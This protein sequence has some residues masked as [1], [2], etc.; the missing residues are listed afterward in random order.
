MHEKY[1]V[2][3]GDGE[4]RQLHSLLRRG[5][6]SATA[7]THAH[8]LLA[9]DQG[10]CDEQIAQSFHVCPM[11]VHNVR[12]CYVQQG[13]PAALYRRAQPA[14]PEK[15]KL[16]GAGEAH[17]IALACG[18]PPE[19]HDRW[20]LRLLADRMVELDYAQ[21]LSHETVRATLKKTS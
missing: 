13:L 7:L 2:Q 18:A 19:G 20:T 1:V 4:R 5:R 9:A 21:S 8:I 10:H 15:H 14:R 12:R 6:A 17:L 3:L 16:D 11:T